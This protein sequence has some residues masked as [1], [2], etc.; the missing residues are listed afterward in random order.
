MSAVF[1]IPVKTWVYR[2]WTEGGT[3]H[4]E[5]GRHYTQS[6]RAEEEKDKE[7]MSNR[8]PIY[9]FLLTYIVQP[10][11]SHS[12]WYTLSAM[13]QFIPLIPGAKINSP[14]LE[15]FCQ[16]TNHNNNKGYW[17]VSG[18]VNISSNVWGIGQVSNL[19]W[20]VSAFKLFLSAVQQRHKTLFKLLIVKFISPQS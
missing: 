20:K 3:A 11:A 14:S 8:I 16:S 13:M 19:P 17:Y 18:S 15:L 2:G 5:D 10:V 1:R 7:E 4:F 6:S 12:Q 9:C